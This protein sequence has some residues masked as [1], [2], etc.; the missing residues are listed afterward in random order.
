[1]KP[2]PT[3]V[4]WEATRVS[5]GDEEINVVEL[6]SSFTKQGLYYHFCFQS[7][8]VVKRDAKSRM[9]STKNY[10]VHTTYDLHYPEGSQPR[11]VCDWKAFWAFWKDNY[12]DIK[13]C[14]PANYT[15]NK[16][17]KYWN[18]LGV[19]SRLENNNIRRQV[20]SK[21]DMVSEVVQR[22]SKNR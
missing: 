14:S 19:V 10:P 17:W 1:M 3:R 5:L 16:C 7:S 8:Y 18:E 2:K 11:K 4:V 12:S 20:Q 9:P 15:C 6:P 13:I 22:N 21:S